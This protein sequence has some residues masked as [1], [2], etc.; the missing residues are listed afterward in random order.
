MNSIIDPLGTFYRFGV[1]SSILN[2]L[3]YK[4]T[5]KK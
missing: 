4:T 1:A 5:V 2:E 3:K